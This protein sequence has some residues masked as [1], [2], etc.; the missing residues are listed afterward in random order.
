MGYGKGKEVKFKG[1][2]VI[3]LKRL[4]EEC[5]FLRM[6]FNMKDVLGVGWGIIFF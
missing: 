6:C 3:W 1:N 4:L 5:N 2:V